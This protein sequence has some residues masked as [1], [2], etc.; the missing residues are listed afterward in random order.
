[1]LRNA[2]AKA[3]KAAHNKLAHKLH[4]DYSGSDT[5]YG[6]VG[7]AYEV[8]SDPYKRAEY[9]RH[10]A[11]GG[12]SAAEAKAAAK[13]AAELRRAREATARAEA[14]MHQAR[15]AAA[16]A[17]A[18]QAQ[19]QG[20]STPETGGAH[21]DELAQYAELLHRGDLNR[22]QARRAEKE[23][24][25]SRQEWFD[26][27]RDR[28]L[29]VAHAPANAVRAVRRMRHPLRW[30][31]LTV[32]ALLVAGVGAEWG[33]TLYNNVRCPV[34]GA[35]A[36]PAAA[37]HPSADKL[38]AFTKAQA[39]LGRSYVVGELSAPHSGSTG[40]PG[41]VD[42]EHP[43]PIYWPGE[44]RG[45]FVG[46]AAPSG[47][48]VAVEGV[49]GYA[50][51]DTPAGQTP[52]AFS[53][54]VIIVEVSGACS[55]IDAK[56]PSVVPLKPCPAAWTEPPPEPPTARQFSGPSE[57]P[58][59]N[60]APNTAL[61]LVPRGC[62]T[63][64]AATPSSADRLPAFTLTTWAGVTLASWDPKGAAL[65]AAVGDILTY[66]IVV[67]Q[68]ARGNA[69]QYYI[70]GTLTTRYQILGNDATLSW[71]GQA[72]VCAGP[73]KAAP[74]GFAAD[75]WVNHNPVAPANVNAA[76]TL[77]TAGCV[78]RPK[79]P[80][81]S[82]LPAFTVTQAGTVVAT[83]DAKTGVLRGPVGSV[84][85]YDFDLFFTADGRAHVSGDIGVT[86]SGSWPICH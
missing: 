58:N 43:A 49:R 51:A 18:R 76:S 42:K 70:D 66:E 16:E 71:K 6:M 15:A 84:G 32:V 24:E 77:S 35:A 47:Q 28:R 11:A 64:A 72:P 12:D 59:E 78:T 69:G 74:R 44:P 39:C 30:C 45:T 21:A 31:A 65:T 62:V 19:T 56:G 23:R 61:K 79:N 50:P 52:A 38:L 81:L 53:E 60:L 46:L 86:A 83:W 75:H 20:R 36:T 1:M 48:R 40:F 82:T 55:Y 2:D 41:V 63:P 4:P 14:A 34:A 33:P 9:D 54:R 73:P 80:K 29:A 68:L 13:A 3:I 7:E 22:D 8:L 85:S 26:R 10:L 25:T 37:G 5:L 57:K 67:P 27:R 17:A